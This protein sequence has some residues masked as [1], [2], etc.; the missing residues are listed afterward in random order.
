MGV[1]SLTLSWVASTAGTPPI[2]YQP[3]FRLT[4]ASTWIAFGPQISGL[5]VVVTGLSPATNYDFDVVAVNSAGSAASA[6]VTGKTDPSTGVA[7]SA[8]GN[9]V[10]IQTPNTVTAPGPPTSLAASSPTTTTM[11]L[12]WAASTG[13]PPSYQPLVKLSTATT[14]VATGSATTGLSATVSGLTASSSYDF[15]V[16]ATN[17]AGSATSATVTASTSAPAVVP[18]PNNTVITSVGPTITDAAGNLWGITTGALASFNGAAVGSPANVTSLAYVNNVVWAKDASGNWYSFVVTSGVVSI[19]VGPTATS[20]LPTTP[21]FADEF[22]SLPLHRVWQSPDNWQLVAPDTT[23][24]RGGPHY[25]ELGTQW[26]VNPFNPNTPISGIY[27]ASSGA[28]QLGMLNTPSAYAAYINAPAQANATMPYVAGLLNSST[29]SYQKFGYYE[30][31]FAVDKLAGFGYQ[32]TLENVQLSGHW[33]PEIDLYIYTNASNVQ[34]LLFQVALPPAGASYATYTTSS[35]AGFDGSVNHAYGIDIQ[36]NFIT[37]YIDNVQVYQ[38]PNPGGV[39]QADKMF[40]FLVT[41]ANYLS[42]TNP[43]T[44]ALPVYAHIDYIRVYTTKP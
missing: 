20:P 44:A 35:A 23:D 2:V 4:G 14:F 41:Y 30:T 33:P 21:V 11:T 6:V 40:M 5:T 18:S 9:L 31:L 24:G 10:I 13:S 3:Q 22:T 39:Y 36:T 7:P 34:T 28:L 12:T 15:A 42:G 43:S 26:W 1:N 37:L 17:S 25:G 32:F 8:P 27:T 29:T 38:T 19:G 16:T